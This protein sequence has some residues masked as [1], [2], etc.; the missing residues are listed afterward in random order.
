AASSTDTPAEPFD[1]NGVDGLEFG[2]RDWYSH[3]FPDDPEG[4]RIDPRTTF[5]EAVESFPMGDGHDF[6]AVTGVVDSIV[7]ERVFEELSKRLDCGY[8]TVYDAWL[9]HTGLDPDLLGTKSTRMRHDIEDM[10][11]AGAGSYA[12]VDAIADHMAADRHLRSVIREADRSTAIGSRDFEK[13]LGSAVAD[14]PRIGRL[15]DD[16]RFKDLIYDMVH[17]GRR[18][19]TPV[20]DDAIVSGADAPA[21]EAGTQSEAGEGRDLPDSGDGLASE[22]V[23]EAPEPVVAAT[24]EAEQLAFDFD[25]MPSGLD[26]RQ[27]RGENYIQTKLGTVSNSGSSHETEE[28]DARK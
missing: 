1:W 6:Y 23:A 7:R 11:G 22:N 25:D 10:L 8:G 2:I 9:H 19:S 4:G 18:F 3:E 21:A 5:R 14:H 15:M 24:I 28:N 13:G 26:S 12:T 20:Q 27:N 17:D 16:D